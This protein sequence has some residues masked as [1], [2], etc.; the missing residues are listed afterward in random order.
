MMGD[1]VTAVTH[2]AP[3]TRASSR[4]SAY[5]ALGL[6]AALLTLTA[7][8]FAKGVA[9][10]AQDQRALVHWRDVLRRPVHEFRPTRF[11]PAYDWLALGGLIGGLSAL[12]WGVA[13]LRTRRLRDQF[14][15]GT[16]PGCDANSDG[17]PAAV[18][19][20]VRWD[21]AGVTVH[22]AGAMQA[23]MQRGG[24]VHTWDE[25][26]A[27]GVVRPSPMLPGARALALPPS[28]NVRVVL[29]PTAFLIR[30]V[31]GVR[32]Q[33]L[34]GVRGPERR[35]LGFWLA[36]V[37]AHLGLLALLTAIPPAPQDL[38]LELGS[39]SQRIINAAWKPTEA[40][41]QPPPSDG[42]QAG[43]AA[44]TDSKANPNASDPRANDSA[45]PRSGGGQH[46]DTDRP[47]SLH[48]ARLA[49]RRGGMLAFLGDR[50]GVFDPLAD[51]GSFD[52]EAGVVDAYGTVAGLGPGSTWGQFGQG[53]GGF[54]IDP[55]GTVGSG[56]YGTIR[57][58]GQDGP[59]GGG[60]GPGWRR[61]RTPGEVPMP[62]VGPI[63]TIG[64]L[65]KNIVRRYVRRQHERVR[66]C[67]E[68]ALLTA[69]NLAGTVTARFVISPNGAVLESQA[70]GIGHPELE[71]C[72][73]QVIE[74]IRFPRAGHNDLAKVTY[75]FEL[76]ALGR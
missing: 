13:R 34:A 73:A 52:Q 76:R 8:V 7:A 38:T 74:N 18:F 35:A 11:G 19:P 59:P 36:S 68:K 56:T 41:P 43:L 55:G 4:R 12:A 53:P 54:G 26:A 58:P 65:D 16:D 63:V 37:G 49:A 39:P 40:E 1:S 47:G 33:P 14:T 28:G 44:P 10:A 66:H 9:V 61:T 50:P 25:L 70:A 75:P 72:V 3:A 45:S 15:I 64:G 60:S 57:W 22:I 67:Y 17:A 71:R 24:Q 51:I 5:L 42:P 2:V 30:S 31:P 32:A 69:P 62:T 20:L 21:D 23:R 46:S 6:A 27:L 29:G 48:D